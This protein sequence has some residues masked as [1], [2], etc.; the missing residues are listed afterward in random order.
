MHVTFIGIGYMGT[1]MVPHLAAAGYDVVIWDKDPKKAAAIAGDHVTVA[2]SLADAVRASKVIITSVMSSDVPAL[3]IG[4]D[5][6]KGITAYLQPGS[7]LIVTSTLDPE[8]IEAIHKTMPP[9]THLLDS[10]IIGGVRYAREASL[11]LIVG[12]NKTIFDQVKP[13]LSVFGTVDYVGPLGNGAKLKLITN[14]GI[15]AAEAGIRE[16]LDLA[17]AYGIDY[18]TTLDLLQRGPMKPVVVRALDETNPRPLKD[19]VADEIELVNA[20]KDLVELPM[21][22]AG[23][24]RLEKAVDAVD[25]EA[26]F[27]DIV[28]KNTSLDKNKKS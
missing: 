8:K 13:I 9:D 20:T 11:V 3:H 24:R 27:S 23:L 21:A 26:R 12:G 6:E 2:D 17:D 15:M 28:H 7:T 25:G 22:K 1:Q 18:D 14:V 4:S 16:T 5:D 10:P 19:S